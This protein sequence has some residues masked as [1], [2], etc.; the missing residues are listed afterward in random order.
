MITII[1]SKIAPSS[2]KLKFL[3]PYY[4]NLYTS[5]TCSKFIP[6]GSVRVSNTVAGSTLEATA[7]LTPDQ[8]VVVVVMNTGDQPITFKLLDDTGGTLLAAQIT[9]VAHSIQ[10]FLYHP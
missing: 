6:R 1:Q 3:I 9:A 7:F 4:F 8:Q 10:T 2:D 5:F